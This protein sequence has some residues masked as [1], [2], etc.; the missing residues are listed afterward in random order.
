MVELVIPNLR[1]SVAEDPTTRLA[2]LEAKVRFYQTEYE[3]LCQRMPN[4]MFVV[5][6]ARDRIVEAND[7]AC[8]LL[9]YSRDQLLASIS[10]SDIHPP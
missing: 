4:A 5:D 8:R 2:E 7:A 1:D 6:P 3:Y 9:G 10:I